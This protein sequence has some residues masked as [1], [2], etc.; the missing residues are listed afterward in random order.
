MARDKENDMKE[1][2]AWIT[3][4]QNEIDDWENFLEHKSL[5]KGKYKYCINWL[6]R[7]RPDV[8]ASFTPTAKESFANVVRNMYS[9]A[10]KAVYDRALSEVAKDD[11]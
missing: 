5:K 6:K 3:K 4:T 10:I 9:D 7:Q 11:E 8:P 2:Q 1:F